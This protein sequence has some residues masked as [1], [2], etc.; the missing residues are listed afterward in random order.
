MYDAL[1]GSVVA[2]G[3]GSPDA[4][5]PEAGSI[6]RPAGCR[7]DVTTSR[8]GARAPTVT[9]FLKDFKPFFEQIQASEHP[10]NISHHRC[11][12][13]FTS[14]M[15]AGILLCSALSLLSTAASFGRDTRC[16]LR[17]LPKVESH[18]ATVATPPAVV[19]RTARAVHVAE[20][21]PP[22]RRAVHVAEPRSRRATVA[23]TVA[24]LVA[25]AIRVRPALRLLVTIFTPGS[26]V[27]ATRAA[28][29]R[30]WSDPT[31]WSHVAF[32]PAFAVALLRPAQRALLPELV[33]TL[34][35]V[36]PLSVLYHRNGERPSPLSTVENGAASLMFLYGCVQHA[37]APPALACVEGVCLATT[38]ATFVGT[39]LLTQFYEPLHL[40][41]LHVVPGAMSLLVA[42]WHR[43]L[44]S[45]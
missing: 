31:V 25:V 33:A 15:H 41:G 17:L 36:V 35:V 16:S 6:S 21:R 44:F 10:P 42:G 32:A 26:Q 45:P 34:G 4:F 39:N 22:S 3:M 43:P 8:G 7:L 27:R 14:T 24:S 2:Y 29:T 28:E 19:G 23:A 30:A 5:R 9:G 18:A 20:P 1:R 12:D 40:W 11:S 38:L 13:A 37:R